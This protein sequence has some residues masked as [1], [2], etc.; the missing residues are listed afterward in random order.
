[1]RP[2][3]VPETLEERVTQATAVPLLDCCG[4]RDGGWREAIWISYISLVTI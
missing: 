4:W 1:M 2:W 3:G